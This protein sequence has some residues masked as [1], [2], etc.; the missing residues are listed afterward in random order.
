M[1]FMERAVDKV[2]TIQDLPVV[3][4]KGYLTEVESLV[5]YPLPGSR[6]TSEFHDG[7]KDVN[8][9]YEIAMKS[10]SS[11]KISEVLWVIQN[12]LESLTDIQSN[13]QSFEFDSI[14]ITNKPYINQ[15][16][17]KS[18]FVFLLDFTAKIT[19]FKQ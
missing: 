3:M 12:E 4:K 6:V 5:M 10:T 9:N 8:L 19:I 17:E 15:V 7:T 18:L 1:D 2:N 16:D 13:D 14:V 11:K